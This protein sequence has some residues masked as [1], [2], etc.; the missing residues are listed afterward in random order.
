MSWLDALPVALLCVVWL[1]LPGLLIT[2]GLGLRSTAAWGLAPVATVAVVATTAVVAQKI[3]VGWSVPLVVV[4]S[5]VVAA[6]VAVVAFLLRRRAPYQRPDP[7]RVTMAALIGLVPAVLVGAVAVM[8]GFLHPDALSQSY[9]AVFHYNAL[10]LILDTHNA[11]SLTLGS[12]GIPGEPGTFYPAAWHDLTSLVVLTGGHGIPVSVNMISGV[13]AIVVWPV[14]CLLLVRQ[15]VGR[16]AAGMAITGVLSLAFTAFP[17]DLLSFG[18]LW[19]NLL[20][21]SIAPAV[22][23][24]VISITGLAKE[25][26]IGRGRAWIMLPVVVVGAG[27]A[28][29]N[30]LFS[31]I[32][33]SLVPIGIA[34]GRRAVRLRGEGRTVR[35]VA[36]CVLALVIFLAAWEWAATTPAFATVRTFYWAPFDTPAAA[37]GEVLL[38][39]TTG[40]SALWLLSIV[41][42][43]GIGLSRRFASLRWLVAGFAISGLLYMITAALNRPDTQ[44]FTGYWYNDPHRL[45]AMMPITAIP[46]AVVAIMYLARRAQTWMAARN[47]VAP[48]GGT[49][50]A[51]PLDGPRGR[52][53]MLVRTRAFAVSTVVIALVLG[54]LT[55]GFYYHRHVATIATRY[56]EPLGDQ[57]LRLVDPAERDFF[58]RIKSEIP[59][60]AVVADNPWD[61]SAMLWALADRHVLFPHL[62]ITITKTQQYLADHLD[63]AATDPEVC[64]AANALHVGYLVVGDAKF[65]PWD[66]RN[67]DYEGFADPIGNPA[68]QLIDSHDKLKLYKL[69]ACDRKS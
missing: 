49:L 66:G 7:R 22:L 42:L 3:G 16:S 60:D 28:H 65:W 62:G 9:D 20:G 31:V 50:A 63:E 68:F 34:V 67:A 55:G 32:A 15:V 18:V 21:M 58:E 41:V 24:V 40:Y 46:L 4:V 56:I 2:Y 64:R 38:N 19:P 48:A 11:S 12:L 33:L 23:A 5:L 8:H 59:A 37:V 57:D 47:W 45:A 36:E 35:G 14:S 44:R 1:F 25:D 53:A 27:F 10:A 43:I 51:D 13:I 39:A 17:W 69:V 6:V 54:A 52:V 26:A 61:G 30:V 29:P